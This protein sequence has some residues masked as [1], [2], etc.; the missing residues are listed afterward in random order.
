[1]QAQQSRKISAFA[2]VYLLVALPM[3]VFENR[4][5]VLSAWVLPALRSL[6][7]RW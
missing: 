7:S 2:V 4:Y 1:M 6:A 5:R 3:I